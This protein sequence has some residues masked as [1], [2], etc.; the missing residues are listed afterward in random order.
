MEPEVERLIKILRT[1]MRV[2]GVTNREIER[3]LGQS[4]SYLSRVFSG[5]IELKAE[6]LI[7]IPRAMGLE[8]AEFFQLAYPRRTEPA[9]RAALQL[10][11]VLQE[12]QL[13]QAPEEKRPEPID[14]ERLEK[15]M[16]ATLRKLMAKEGNGGEKKG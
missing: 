3:K 9:S 16:I 15:M 8:P 12:L 4:P 2:L 7:L 5:G 11:E 6:H 10:R 14:E 13:P 1:A